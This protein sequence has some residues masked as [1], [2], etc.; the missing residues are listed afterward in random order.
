MWDGEKER[1]RETR[2]EEGSEGRGMWAM[3]WQAGKR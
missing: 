2:L 1:G 3:N